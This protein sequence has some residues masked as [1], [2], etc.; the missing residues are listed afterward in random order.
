MGKSP[1]GFFKPNMLSPPGKSVL[2][3]YLVVETNFQIYWRETKVVVTMGIPWQSPGEWLG[4]GGLTTRAQG[5]ILGQG[6][7]ILQAKHVL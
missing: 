3:S 2:A 1:E 7:K 5:S 4:L 6:T